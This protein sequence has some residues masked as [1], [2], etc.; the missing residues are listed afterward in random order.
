MN[1][2]YR[3]V[4]K[5]R[6]NQ[7]QQGRNTPLDDN[8]HKVQTIN[9]FSIIQLN[10]EEINLDSFSDLANLQEKEITRI[11]KKAQAIEEYYIGKGKDSKI[12][13]NCFNCLMNNF[14]E[15][16]L[17]YFAKRSDLLTYLKYC[18]YFLKKIL[19]LDT[20]IYTENKYDL[21]KCD[22]TNYL[23][24][25]LSNHYIFLNKLEIIFALT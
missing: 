18:F 2:I 23:N 6:K 5:S 9:G 8:L 12:N 4:S 7:K 17:L 19:F 15:N 25:L 14:H 24:I 21:D 22:D 13:E 3:R 10:E 20:Q 16:E 11:K 1:R